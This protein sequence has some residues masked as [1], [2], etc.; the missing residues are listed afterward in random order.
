MKHLGQI[1]KGVFTGFPVGSDKAQQSVD[2]SPT[3]ALH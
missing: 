2:G 3:V 1:G